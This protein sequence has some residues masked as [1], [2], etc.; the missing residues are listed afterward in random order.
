MIPASILTPLPP[1]RRRSLVAAL[2]TA[3]MCGVILIA[4]FT[5]HL[6]YNPLDTISSAAEDEVPD[7]TALLLADQYVMTGEIPVPQTEAA[8]P[9][10]DVSSDAVATPEP[11]AQQT[12]LITTDKPQAVTTPEPPPPAPD[13]KPTP[14]QQKSEEI[15][16]QVKFG[17]DQKTSQSSTN[18]PGSPDGNAAKAAALSGSPGH[19]LTGRTLAHWELPARTAPSGSV[20][21]RVVVDRQGQVIEATVKSSTGAAATETVRQ[22]CA[23]AA[24]K[25]RFSVNLDAPNRQTGTITYRFTTR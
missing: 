17:T 9:K 13:T 14:N 2:I 7:T 20:T 18:A 21:V 8:V 4:V 12:P 16:R 15:A 6:I 5:T 10:P 23:A 1:S 25:S 11:P 24:R 3:L 19:T 22:A